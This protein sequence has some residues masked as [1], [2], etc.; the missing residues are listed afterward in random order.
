M[1]NALLATYNTSMFSIARQDKRITRE[2]AQ[3][4]G[5]N[6]AGRYVKNRIDPRDPDWRRI[7]NARDK[8]RNTHYAYTLPWAE[9]QRL[10]NALGVDEYQSAM[11]DCERE[12]NAAVDTFALN[13]EQKKTDAQRTLGDYYC[14]SDYPSE[15]GLRDSFRFSVTLIPMPHDAQFESVAD[16]IGREKAEA[17]AADLQAKQRQQM[18]DATASLWRRLYDALEHASRQLNHGERIHAS[19]L[20]NLQ[21]LADMLPLLNINNDAELEKRRKELSALFRSFS[22][23]SVK[24]KA[25]RKSC[26]AQVDDILRRLPNI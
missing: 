10:I 6:K 25:N 11:A 21:E 7:C 3:R 20:G 2:M 1:K 26:A 8:A 19:V 5:S 4:I 15:Q 24:D 17:L 12:F 18:A 13:F 22:S 9:G 14:E 23:E 16:L